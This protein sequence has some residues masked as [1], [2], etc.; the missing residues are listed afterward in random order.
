MAAGVQEVS[1]NLMAELLSVREQLARERRARKQHADQDA[2]AEAAQQ[3]LLAQV[4]KNYAVAQRVHAER[5]RREEGDHYI[6]GLRE[7]MRS[8][9]ARVRLSNG[10]SCTGEPSTTRSTYLPE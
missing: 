10:V 4:E 1:E 6:K 2:R 5:A 3:A 9:A 7:Q 8:A